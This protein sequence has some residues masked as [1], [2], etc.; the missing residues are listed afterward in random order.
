MQLDIQELPAIRG[1]KGHEYKMSAI[2]LRTRIKYSQIVTQANSKAL[3]IFLHQARLRLPP[4]HLVV[5]DNAMVFTMKY[6]AHPDRKTAFE[7]MAEQLGLRHFRIQRFS[8]WQ[9]GFIERSNR[10][11]NEEC[12]TRQEFTDSEERRYVHRLWEM[13]YNSKRVHQG[14]HGQTPESVFVRDYPFHAGLAL[15]PIAFRRPKAGVN[16]A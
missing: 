1:G 6:T 4:F 9:N 16:N 8:P 11:D 14:L 3:A 15:Q 10:T 7:C 13:D 2:H 5:T 12:F